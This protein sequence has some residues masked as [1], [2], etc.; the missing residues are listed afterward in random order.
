MSPNQTTRTDI[1][2]A[3][4]DANRRRILELLAH[5]E[6]TVGELTEAIGIAQPS[7]SQHLVVLRGVGLV[8]A[9]PRGRASVN[10]L[11]RA[12]LNEVTDWIGSL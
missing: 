10:R 8:E 9:T 2:S 6:H 12:P 4:G 3:I 7:I 1:F 11:V 5:K